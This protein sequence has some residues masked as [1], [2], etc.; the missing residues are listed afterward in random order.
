MST[1][2][3]HSRISRSRRNTHLSRDNSQA[4]HRKATATPHDAYIYS[5]AVAVLHYQLQPRQK[6]I[7]HVAAPPR[8]QK[9]RTSA[10]EVIGHD[11]TLLKA[12]RSNRVPEGFM[13]AL[14][15][16]LTY[17]LIGKERLPEYNDALIKRTF[18][19]FLNQ[20]KEKHFRK[21]VETD[22]RVEDLLLIFFSKASSELQKGN[23]GTG[24]THPEPDAWKLM[25]DRH[26]ALFIRLINAILRDHNWDSDRPDLAERLKTMERK[27]LIHDQNLASEA[28]RN[29]GAGGTSIEVEVPLTYDVKD[30]PLAM[31]VKRVF[32]KEYDQVQADVN[33]HK[34]NWTQKAAL[35]DLKSYQTHL[36]L[37]GN[38]RTLSLVDFDYDD[39]YEAWKKSE[40]AEVSQ[41]ILNM[42]QNNIELAKTSTGAS[43]FASAVPSASGATVDAYAEISKKL[44]N[45]QED[46]NSYFDQPVDMG[47]IAPDNHRACDDD[48]TYTFIPPNPR[49]HF[50]TVLKEALSVDLKD[51]EVNPSPDNIFLFS[52]STTELLSELALRWRMPLF[53]R[54][55]LLL[56]VI[57]EKYGQADAGLPVVD[58]TFL[59]IKETH[60]THE[61][62]NRRLSQLNPEART[63]DWKKWTVADYA[64]HK[65][66]LSGIHS[67]ILRDLFHLLMGVYEPKPPEI[68]PAMYIIQE[69]IYSDELCSVAENELDQFAEELENGLIEV[70]TAKYEEIREKVLR[71]VEESN[72]MLDFF[73]VI[74]VGKGVKKLAEK[75]AKRYRKNPNIMGVSPFAIL[76]KVMFPAFAHDARSFVAHIIEIA[77]QRGEEIPIADGFDLYRELVEIRGV[78]ALDK[79]GT[80]F[81]FNVEELLQ[82]FVWRWIKTT[83]DSVVGWSENAIKHDEFAVRN[84]DATRPPTDDERHSISSI[85]TFRSF[86]EIVNQITQ[87]NWDND[88]QYAKFMTSL[89]KI[90]GNGISRYCEL[91]EQLFSKEMSVESAE[92]VAARAQL[93]NSERYWQLARDAWNA[94]NKVEAY[95]F[96]TKSLVKL[97]NIEYAITELDKLERDMNV[98]A[99]AAVITRNTPPITHQERW[100]KTEKYV[101]TIKIIE[102]EDLKPCDING[103]SDPY[104]VLGDEY[105]KRLAKTR[106]IYGNL[107]PRWDESVDITTTGAINIIATVWDWDALGDH[108]CVG[109]SSLKLDPHH[110]RDYI[111]REY[112]LPLDT[113]GRV[114]V[115]VSMEGERDDIQFYFGKAFRTLKRTERDMTRQITDKLNA[116][117]QHMLS[118]RTLR[119]LL[120]KGI[121]SKFNTFMKKQPQAPVVPSLI[122]ATRAIQ[123][124]LDYF[125]E[126]FAIMN[127]TLTQS[128]M[129]AVM[130]RLWKE[131]LSQ[132]EALLVPPLSDKP[133]AQ[134]PLSQPEL[135]IVYQW[136]QTLFDFFHAVDEHTGIAQGVPLDVLKSPKYHDLKNLAFFYTQPTEDLIRE[137]ERMASAS[138]ARAASEAARLNRLSAPAHLGAPAPMTFSGAPQGMPTR[139]H[140]TILG[141]RNLGTMRKAKEE[142]R[143]EA[144]AEP[145]DDMIL[146]ILR[147]RPEATMYLTQR[148]R[149]RERLAAARAAEQIV[150]R[151]LMGQSSSGAAGRGIRAGSQGGLPIR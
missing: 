28:S 64:L 75:I 121:A 7:Q 111:P 117:I 6:R 80:Q 125:D 94:N 143:R 66:A 114:L 62:K 13:A 142:K 11:I 118:E 100:K 44:A 146:R 127:Q 104:V 106:I 105:Q 22:R 69:H 103:L 20:F 43:A 91:I 136:L 129:T 37:G 107:N 149:Q 108:D 4:L 51:P 27:L 92:E 141:S 10:S 139:R 144:Q 29:G 47:N 151:S 120:S 48:L 63:Q 113:Q 135:D 42:V 56:D 132:V 41:M 14:D 130:S 24:P 46:D 9:A 97:N 40:T 39:A 23:I 87:L 83:E 116:Y 2:S 137:S 18:G 78:Y 82:D 86:N 77:Q 150:M 50:R 49:D 71:E 96:S 72:G 52:K 76:A 54:L 5:L 70:A 98:E 148:T 34:A 45:N 101:F 17:V 109:R 15:K 55:V 102:G 16:R 99:C 60:G 74:E 65:Q 19:A 84:D 57:R 12:N 93:T 8:L 126:N 147:M 90:I 128:A 85:D 124:L 59:Y 26:C 53:S 131:V 68:G 79:S 138:A 36:N 119:Q 133:S 58:A 35:Q 73:H 115:R 67:T 112:W 33:K 38:R 31:I 1:S 110:F 25:V 134:R 145:S 88:L 123:P 21:G 81:K 30:M 61:K 95:N 122:E 140:K 89:S 3:R 32:S